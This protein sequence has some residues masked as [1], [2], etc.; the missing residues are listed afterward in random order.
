M[1]IELGIKEL[2]VET[3]ERFLIIIERNIRKYIESKVDAKDLLDFEIS[4]EINQEETLSIDIE[5]EV[6][7]NNIS[8]EEINKLIEEAIDKAENAITSELKNL[9]LKDFSHK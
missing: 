3:L 1:T 7:I 6:E 4:A 5:V 2:P 9:K 8:T